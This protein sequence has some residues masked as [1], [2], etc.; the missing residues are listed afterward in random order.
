M[1]TPII[2]NNLLP[3]K[4][5]TLI[6]IARL[7]EV[8]EIYDIM[9]KIKGGNSSNDVPTE[10]LKSAIERDEIA[11]ELER[12]Y[13]TI[14]ES[15]CIPS[16]WGHSK[17]ITIWKGSSKGSSSDPKAYRGIQIG[18]TLCKIM[19]SLLLRRLN[20]W[21]NKQLSDHQ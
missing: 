4:V 8:D 6:F 16:A 7:L 21:Y 19:I 3:C 13:K 18:S 5:L 15:K 1:S 12:I 9:K 17:L 10:F 20:S 14:S 2:F 11:T